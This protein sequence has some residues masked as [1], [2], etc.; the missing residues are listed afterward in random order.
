MRLEWTKKANDS[1]LNATKY[2][3]D[4]DTIAARKVIAAIE[5]TTDFLL[6]NPYIGRVK[7]FSTTR[8][9]IMTRYPFIIWYSFNNGLIQI[10]QVKYNLKRL[11]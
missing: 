8:E 5:K 6:K 11:L 3:R 7:R 1:L 10:L 2:I 9:L 4:N